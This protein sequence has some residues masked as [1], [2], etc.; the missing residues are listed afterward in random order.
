MECLQWSGCQEILRVY[1]GPEVMESTTEPFPK[2][3]HGYRAREAAALCQGYYAIT[4][5]G[6]QL[7]QME[8][9][10]ASKLCC[11]LTDSDVSR[12]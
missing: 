5:L 11:P 7:Y 12:S 10:W 9:V 1:S 6:D 2:S 4:D 3:S 8:E